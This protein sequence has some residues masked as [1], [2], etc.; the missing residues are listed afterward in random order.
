MSSVEFAV[1]ED[2]A[3]FLQM[4]VKRCETHF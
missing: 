3:P 1:I 4:A 2:K